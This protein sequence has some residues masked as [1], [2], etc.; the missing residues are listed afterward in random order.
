MK[1]LILLLAVALCVACGPDVT[2]REWISEPY[3]EAATTSCY[4]SGYCYKMGKFKFSTMC[5]G[6]KDGIA[7][8]Q[9]ERLY[10]EDGMQKDRVR[11]IDFEATGSCQ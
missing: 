7:T 8:Y 9:V 3:Q 2:S 6:R 10:F 5:P 11:R 4:K 1:R